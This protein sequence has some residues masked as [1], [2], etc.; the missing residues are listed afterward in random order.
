MINGI[1]SN[2]G[3]N[4]SQ[5][6]SKT[7]GKSILGKDDFLNLMIQQMKYQDPMNPMDSNQYAAQLAQFTSLEQLQNINKSL[8]ASLNANF[9]LAQAVNNTMS[10]NLIG[11]EVKFNSPLIEYNGQE[12]ITLDYK[13]AGN[14]H[15]GVIKI[16]DA[17]GQVVKTI[18]LSELSAG[19]YRVD[20]D[21][22]NSA[23]KKVVAGNYKM[24]ISAKASNESDINTELY[25]LGLISGIRFTENGTMVMVG[26]RQ[27]S[28]SEIFEIISPKDTGGTNG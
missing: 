21:F 16:K 9:Q 19:E 2:S 1:S 15:T 24:E 27:Y 22:T 8:D 25:Q 4:G 6:N 5:Q 23:G 18:E 28:L 10:T 11:K 20:W 17:N 13:L 14:A 26:N 7:T 12:K 3:I